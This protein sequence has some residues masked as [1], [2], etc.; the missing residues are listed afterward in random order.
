MRTEFPHEIFE[1]DKKELKAMRD[2]GDKLM[3]LSAAQAEKLK[4]LTP[5]ER[6][7]WMRKNRN[8]NKSCPCG[9]GKKFKRC[10]W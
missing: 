1:L 4:G 5:D 6:G 3:S 7:D 8:R 2:A 10:C 9:S